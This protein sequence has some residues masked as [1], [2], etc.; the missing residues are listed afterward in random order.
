MLG[1]TPLAASARLKTCM[2]N[3][4]LIEGAV[5]TYRT[6]GAAMFGQDRFNGNGTASTADVLVPSCL[7]TAP[8]C[9]TSGRFYWVDATGRVTGDM[10]AAGF[11]TGHG[12]Y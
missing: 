1:V 4:R 3:Q 6:T 7:K 10:N 12:H 2:S 5:E 11:T 8:K 9:P